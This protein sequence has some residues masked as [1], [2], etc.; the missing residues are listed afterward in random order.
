MVIIPPEVSRAAYE[1]AFEVANET[2]FRVARE[3][4]TRAA[5]AFR[6]AEGNG[7]QNTDSIGTKTLEQA[8]DEVSQKTREAAFKAA[9]IA[10]FAAAITVESSKGRRNS[11]TAS[12]INLPQTKATGLANHRDAS[13][14]SLTATFRAATAAARAAT[15]HAVRLVALDTALRY[16][17]AADAAADAL[18]KIAT[19]NVGVSISKDNIT[20][21]VDATR[22]AAGKAFRE[23]F[24]ISALDPSSDID[25]AAEILERS[26]ATGIYIT[27]QKA[28]ASAKDEAIVTHGG[29]ASDC[30]EAEKILLEISYDRPRW[31]RLKSSFKAASGEIA[32]QIIKVPGLFTFK[33]TDR[34][35][36]TDKENVTSKDAASRSETQKAFHPRWRRLHRMIL[37]LFSAFTGAFYGA[38]H[39]T[40]WNSPWFPTEVEHFLWQVSCVMSSAV[41]VPVGLLMFIPFG[42]RGYCQYLLI[43]LCSIT[44]AVFIAARSYIV[45]ESFL[46][47]RSLPP[48]A[49]T[50]VQWTN[51]IPHI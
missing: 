36:K 6:N 50:T 4:I 19:N 18:L 11:N 45:A 49:F 37:F 1:D 3:K 32:D 21:A 20:F 40:K 44:W 13:K 2:A 25:L 27:A 10:A 38:I 30:I 33:S 9:Y 48:A 34:V 24:E 5:K 29:E 22:E 41:F 17:G 28:I 31:Q 23:Y 8:L 16:D 26:T 15:R 47:L 14:T 39:M 35:R 51:A 43:V 12:N 42:G 46:S 7:T